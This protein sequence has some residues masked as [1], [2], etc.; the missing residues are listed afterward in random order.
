MNDF[1]GFF[2]PVDNVP[3]VNK[4]KA[5][6][7]IPIKFSLNGDQGLE[8]LDGSPLINLTS[9][10]TWAPTND[11]TETVTS[12]SGTEG[13][14]GH[15]PKGNSPYTYSS[16]LFGNPVSYLSHCPEK[17]TRWDTGTAGTDPEK[18]SP[19]VLYC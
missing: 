1:S 15:I 12:V 4:V 14:T 11:L 7:A 16:G 2:P 3:F 6:R 8:I 9:C 18:N 10:D 17:R 19:L 5:G 13:R